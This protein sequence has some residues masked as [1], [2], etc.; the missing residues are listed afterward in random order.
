MAINTVAEVRRMLSRRWR[1]LAS[2][3]PASV[4]LAVLVAYWLPPSYRATSTIM[5]EPQS[6]PKEMVSATV[7]GIEDVAIYAENEL[8]LTRRRVMTPDRLVSIVKAVDPYPRMRNA[9]PELKA[10]LLAANVTVERVDPI[11]LKPLDQSAAFS[12]YYDNPD[13]K[14]AAAVAAQLSDLY[15]SYNRRT[16]TEQASAAY[17]FLQGQSREVEGSMAE[18]EQRLA[19]FKAEYGAALPEMQTHNMSEIDRAQHD[20]ESIQQQE[21]IAEEK[22]SQLQLQ[23]NSLSPTLTGAV[24][25]SRLELAKLRAE[26]A[27]AHQK[28]TP[29]HPEVKRLE[30]AV[31]DMNAQSAAS[32]QPGAGKPDNPEYLAVA[33]QLSA[34][35]HQLAALRASEMRERHDR[36]LYEEHLQTTPNVERQYTQLQR[37][38]SAARDRYDDIQAKMKNA[39]LARTME[40]EDRGE[41]FS[42]LHA[43]TVPR[44]PFFPNRVGIILLGILLGC[45]AALGAAAFADASDPTVRG[46]TD[47]Q[48]IMEST[49]LGSIPV[50][51]TARDRRLYRLK[52]GS[53]LAAYSAGVA[54][55]AL[56]I[57]IRT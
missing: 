15:L 55:M 14:L 20:I 16:R 26:L 30:R 12:I 8:E 10:Q 22:E 35:R 24:S 27:E 25:D 42:L 40:F 21:L 4:L 44:R 48:E 1:Y 32:L 9:T 53:A 41:K 19:K 51:L 39:A 11:T 34:A 50:L 54:L 36:Q 31:A 18:M 37:E 57:Y 47:L 7:R 52:W 56:T 5:L 43:P 13:P 23:L 46:Q 38:Y 29:E 28:Y 6:I 49:P 45:G 33:D 2:I 17:D 3:L